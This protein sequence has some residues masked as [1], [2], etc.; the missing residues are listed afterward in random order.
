MRGDTALK[1]VAV[2]GC[3]VVPTLTNPGR[4]QMLLED[5]LELG[6]TRKKTS[7]QTEQSVVELLFKIQG[8]LEDGRSREV[9]SGSGVVKC[10]LGSSGRAFEEIQ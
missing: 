8:S 5:G 10:A 9:S 4:R 1:L 6:E 2:R 3:A 7:F